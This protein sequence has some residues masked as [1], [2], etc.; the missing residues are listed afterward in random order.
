MENEE[1]DISLFKK[2]EEKGFFELKTINEMKVPLTN[3]FLIVPFSKAA[4]AFIECKFP[5]KQKA[6]SIYEIK[7]NKSILVS[8][9]FLSGDVIILKFCEDLSSHIIP[10]LVKEIFRNLSVKSVIMLSSVHYRTV[11][12]LDEEDVGKLLFYQNQYSNIAIQ[13][14]V[15]FQSGSQLEDEKAAI[16]AFC[17]INKIGCA[18]SVALSDSIAPSKECLHILNEIGKYIKELNGEL[19]NIEN[20]LKAV[21]DPGLDSLYS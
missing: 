7:N 13:N 1:Y 6:F 11:N 3:S 4:K 12:F 21:R 19:H 9:V 20:N 17:E 18:I 8:E 10:S 15:D 16:F 5:N 2:F 14:I